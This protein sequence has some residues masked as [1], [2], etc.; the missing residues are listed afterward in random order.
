MAITKIDITMLEDDSGADNLVKLDANAKIPAGTGANL[1]NK[2]GP[3]TSASDPAID[4]NKTL[5]TE[6]VNT[7]N[8]EIYLCT[9]ATAGANIWT[10]VGA[11]SG[12]VQPW[13]F[14]GTNYGYTSGGYYTPGTNYYNIIDKF[15]FASDANAADVGNLSVSRFGVG[16]QS[17]TTHGYSSAGNTG[18]NSNVIDKFPFA[19]DSNATDVGDMTIAQMTTA[20]QT[21]GTYGYATGDYPSN[22]VI[23]KF[24]FA[25]DSNAT[26]I[27]NL[28]V[29]RDYVAGQSSTTHG[30]ST[31]GI[32]A[33]TDVIDKFPFASDTNATD[34]G[35]LTA[36][37]GDVAGQS[38]TTYGYTS[39][40]SNVIDKYPFASDTNATDVG[41]L[42]VTRW[43]VS[44][45]QY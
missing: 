45:Q 42:T 30:Y 15:P 18:S 36:G 12:D 23:Q 13:A 16:S 19:T 44:G 24:P 32:A 7:T 29:A 20:G 37:R 6:W 4:S 1:L 21:S 39:G 3:L 40:R 31:G 10:N 35:N 25:T 38:S 34:V 22:D 2:P 17:S 43:A 11:G 5:G 28:T 8:G 41:D 33:G 27:G 9:D 26:D 14:G